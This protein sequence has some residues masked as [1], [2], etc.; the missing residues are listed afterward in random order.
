MTFF[1]N[2]LKLQICPRLVSDIIIFYVKSMNLF[3]P[4][5][6]DQDCIYGRGQYSF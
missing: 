5:L 4:A 3:K 1:I 6:E 2:K